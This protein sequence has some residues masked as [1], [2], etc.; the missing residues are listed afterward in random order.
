MEEA[1][2]TAAYIHSLKG[3]TARGKLIG[4]EVPRE[5]I[6][7]GAWDIP[8]GSSE[9][10]EVAEVRVKA[11]PGSSEVKESSEVRKFGSSEVRK[12]PPSEVRK[13]RRSD[14][15]R[16]GSSEVRKFAEV[17]QFTSVR[18]NSEVRSIGSNPKP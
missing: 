15:Q 14:V 11:P 1:R 9:V 2:P 4:S 13:F 12:A 3:S 8:F 6:S 16:F 5:A 17:R 7:G 10:K 18:G